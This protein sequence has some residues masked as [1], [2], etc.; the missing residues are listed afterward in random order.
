[1]TASKAKK[2][3]LEPESEALSATANHCLPWPRDGKWFYR[4]WKRYYGHNFINAGE[5]CTLVL[6][7]FIGGVALGP[8]PPPTR[9]VK[10]IVSEE[11]RNSFKLKWSIRVV[12]G[13]TI[14][15]YK[16]RHKNGLDASGAKTH[17]NL[18]MGGM[19]SDPPSHA[20]F[21][22]S[23]FPK[24]PPIHPKQRKSCM[25]PMVTYTFP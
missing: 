10:T 1:M 25:N 4:L 23:Q 13:Y 19:P 17:Q 6:F 16:C 5:V 15:N 24:C 21:Y 14:H 20:C 22:S 2:R 7:H 3:A 18:I 12:K 8:P 9:S 11:S